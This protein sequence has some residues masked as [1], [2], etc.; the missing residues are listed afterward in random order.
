MQK[1]TGAR[2]LMLLEN[3]PY[4]GD[5]RVYR[6][7]SSLTA[8][9]YQVSII[10]PR[11]YTE[12]W[13]EQVEGVSVF[14]FPGCL[15]LRGPLGYAWRY[16][17][18]TIAVFL[19]SLYVCVRKGFDVVHTHNPP[20]TFFVIAA[21]YKLFGRQFIYDHHDLMPEI[22][23]A[24]QGGEGKPS[25]YR[26]LHQCEKWSCRFADRIIATNESYKALEAARH[27]IPSER[28]SVVRNGP[29]EKN[30]QLLDPDPAVRDRAGT[31]IGYV[32][33]IGIQDGVDYLLRA[34][35]HLIHDLG[36]QDVCCVIVGDG[37]AM[38]D[39][40]ILAQELELQ[41]Y[42]LFTGF[43]YDDELVRRY[44][45]SM[46]ICT[47][48]DPSNSLNDRSTMI[49]MMEYM[50]LAKPIVAFDL[51]EH[52]VTAGESALYA[53]PNDVCDF[54][55]QIAR[56]IEDPAQGKKIGEIGKERIRTEMAWAYQETHLFQA[57][58]SIGR[59]GRPVVAQE[60]ILRRAA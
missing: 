46:D 16:F 25:I 56:L 39:L 21:F 48:P 49:K 27:Q 55:R 51:P 22:Y 17:Y 53:R 42:L 13:T 5:V 9:G 24:Q 47:D 4:P 50:A 11:E 52:R 10:C 3:G 45:S 58:E 14:R 7:A 8:A 19:I 15:S 43:I 37:A 6:E 20:D 23:L 28:I 1:T 2:V 54:A 26:M 35:H 30:M 44:V 36:K 38:T 12:P 32:G 29:D 34:L 57:Y 33:T 59:F 41:Q 31:I 60:S 18:A 40:R